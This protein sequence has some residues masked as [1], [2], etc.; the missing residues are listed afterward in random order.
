[1]PWKDGHLY[2]HSE[3]YA[4]HSYGKFSNQLPDKQAKVINL[5]MIVVMMMQNSD[6]IKKTWILLDTCYTDRV[7]NNLDFVEDV[8]ICAKHKELKVLING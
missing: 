7:T 8:N 5:G 6:V 4:C 2:K 3:C 1:M